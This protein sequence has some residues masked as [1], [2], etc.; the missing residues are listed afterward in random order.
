MW[1]EAVAAVRARDIDALARLVLQDPEVV[2][3][4]GPEGLSLLMLAV[5]QR[6]PEVVAYLREC[7]VEPD[8]FEA[9]AIG[10]ADRVRTLLA[11]QPGLVKATSGDGWTPLHLAAHFGQQ[12]CVRAL[13]AGGAEV[14]A[15]S[16][17]ANGNTPLHA[18]AAGAQPEAIEQLLARG[19]DP[20][21][22]DAQGHTPL[23]IAAG[24][25]PAASLAALLDAGAPPA[26]RNK[27]GK[28]ALDVA[29]ERSK[30]EI[31]TFLEHRTR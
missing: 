3:A 5:Y 12:E 27:D 6:A 14:D 17:N 29:R 15:R 16:A 19:A 21:A 26:A 2:H 1:D 20:R 8:V 23:H 22:L 28:T 7:G 9:A 24:A 25:G 30:P 13:L 4:R 10:D 18:A 31:A 11:H